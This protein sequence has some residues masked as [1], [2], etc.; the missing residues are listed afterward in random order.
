MQGRKLQDDDRVSQ[1]HLNQVTTLQ[2]GLSF[3][4]LQ[5]R[6]IR[7]Q[8]RRLPAAPG[9]CLQWQRLAD[10]V[11]AFGPKALHSALDRRLVPVPDVE[12]AQQSSCLLTSSQNA[13]RFRN[14]HV[15][16][17]LAELFLCIPGGMQAVS[18]P[19][20]T[21]LLV[22]RTH[23]VENALCDRPC[24]SVQ[25]ALSR[26][27]LFH[28]HLFCERTSNQ[29]GMLFHTHEYPAMGPDFKIDLGYCQRGS[30]LEFNAHAMD[31]RNLLWFGVRQSYSVCTA[32]F[33]TP[34]ASGRWH[35]ISQLCQVS[36]C[37]FDKGSA[38][39]FA[40]TG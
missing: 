22:G 37:T 21:L 4:L 2:P 5:D 31:F 26:F 24:P 34:L 10:H 29:L 18:L 14:R 19:K 6:K 25:V 9:P 33:E 40:V 39:H 1:Q 35:A 12:G 38:M 7:Q 11:S 27:D 3:H 8:L 36:A 20:V 17:W 23:K 32:G 30:N 16:E 15:N 13:R 28:A